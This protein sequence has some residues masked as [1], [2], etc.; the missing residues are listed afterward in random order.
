MAVHNYSV[1]VRLQQNDL[2]LYSLKWPEVVVAFLEQWKN[3]MLRD[4]L[5][6]KQETKI[7][8]LLCLNSLSFV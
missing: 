1:K 4:G 5:N 2:T 3:A 6:G 7:K 8:L